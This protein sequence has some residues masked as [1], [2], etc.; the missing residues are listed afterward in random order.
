MIVWCIAYIPF[1]KSY[2]RVIIPLYPTDTNEED[3]KL[4]I[5]YS[6]LGKQQ[7]N[8]QKHGRNIRYELIPNSTL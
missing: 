4:I 3:G 8:N 2:T 5:I 6:L 1:G 7:I